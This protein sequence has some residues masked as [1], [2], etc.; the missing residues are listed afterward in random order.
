MTVGRI[1]RVVVVA[2]I[3]AGGNLIGPFVAQA[4][5]TE[6]CA[7][8]AP[9]PSGSAG[10]PD[11][12]EGMPLGIPGRSSEPGGS[13]SVPEESEAQESQTQQPQD[14]QPQSQQSAPVQGAGQIDGGLLGLPGLL[15]TGSAAVGSAAAGAGSAP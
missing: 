12:S 14:R 3:V 15:G 2:G 4:Q 5:S 10:G 11:D 1:A 6:P 13:Q 7:Q 9:A 8:C